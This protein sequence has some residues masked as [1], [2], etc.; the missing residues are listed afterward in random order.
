MT[1]EQQIQGDKNIVLWAKDEYQSRG[2]MCRGHLRELAYT[3]EWERIVSK[4]YFEP[5]PTQETLRRAYVM[6]LE[7]TKGQE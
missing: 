5:Q 7:H 4:A 3:E 1:L 6:L 2:G